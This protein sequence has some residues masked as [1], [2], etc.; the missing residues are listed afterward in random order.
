MASMTAMDI[1][2]DLIKRAKSNIFY[3][4]K[5]RELRQQQQSQ[6]GDQEPNGNAASA[7]KQNDREGDNMRIP[8]SLLHHR[9][10][11]KQREAAV[12]LPPY[13]RLEFIAGN[14][15]DGETTLTPPVRFNATQF[16]TILWSFGYEMGASQ[17]GRCRDHAA[18]YKDLS[19][20]EAGRPSGA[21]TAELEELPQ[22]VLSNRGAYCLSVLF[23]CLHVNP[24][25]CFWRLHL[26]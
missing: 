25:S 26:S 16:D 5:L 9:T 1:D 21:G 3:H 17:L 13:D 11:S 4:Q 22:E 24:V 10:S 15:I 20:A 8:I 2:K 19:L 18:V 14:F 7:L 23:S 6:E 12:P